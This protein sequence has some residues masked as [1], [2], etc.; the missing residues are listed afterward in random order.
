MWE[1]TGRG[2]APRVARVELEDAAYLEGYGNRPQSRTMSRM[3]SLG[4]ALLVVSAGCKSKPDLSVLPSDMD[5]W[6]CRSD[7]CFAARSLEGLPRCA[8]I[9]QYGT[10][11]YALSERGHKVNGEFQGCETSLRK[12]MKLDPEIFSRASY[13]TFPVADDLPAGIVKGCLPLDINSES[14]SE[15]AYVFT[16]FDKTDEKKKFHAF[17][18]QYY[19]DKARDEYA[20]LDELGDISGCEKAPRRPLP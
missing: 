10:L 15:T 11:S 9:W 2:R 18:S 4:L 6:C 1:M 13:E 16:Y 7:V 12:A 5:T 19:C 14:A 8:N 3:R 20:K 17:K